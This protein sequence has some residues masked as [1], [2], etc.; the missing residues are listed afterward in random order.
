MSMELVDLLKQES[1]DLILRSFCFK[2][3]DCK[4]DTF[5]RM[6]GKVTDSKYSL[7]E[8]MNVLRLREVKW[9]SQSYRANEH[10]S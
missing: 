9:L 7:G 5:W 2:S 10:Q 8:Q 1:R 4:L 6:S 3:W